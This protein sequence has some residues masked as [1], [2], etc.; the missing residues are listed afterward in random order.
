MTKTNPTCGEEYFYK[1]HNLLLSSC[2]LL[3]NVFMA[4]WKLETDS[5]WESTE[6]NG[7]QVWEGLGSLVTKSNSIKCAPKNVIQ[8]GCLEEWDLPTLSLLL[9]YYGKHRDVYADDD[10]AV[11]S[12]TRIATELNNSSKRTLTRE[13]YNKNLKTFRKC[14]KVFQMKDDHV[15]DLIQ[16]V[17]VTC[18]S[19]AWDIIKNLF[20]K[21]KCHMYSR[22]F[23]DAIMCYTQAIGVPGL[24]PYHQSLAY[25]KRSECY[26]NL[27]EH[28]KARRDPEFEILFDNAIA[29]A[30][31][32]LQFN[33][34]SWKAHQILGQCFKTRESYCQALF[35]F[36]QAL[37]CSP[38]QHQV[39][40]VLEFCRAHVGN[41]LSKAMEN[42]ALH[43]VIKM[44]KVQFFKEKAELEGS[45]IKGQEHVF[46]GHQYTAGWSVEH[47]DSEAFRHYKK[48]AQVQNPEGI[49]HVAL[50]YQ[51]G[52]GVEKELGS[53]HHLFLQAALMSPTTRGF[54]TKNKKNVGVAGAQHALGLMYDNGIHVEQDFAKAAEW[55]EKG[56]EN[57]VGESA[58]NLGNL[59]KDGKKGVEW[60]EKKAAKY[61]KQALNLGDRNAAASLMYY[62][63]KHM[64]VEEA[65]VMLQKGRLLGNSSLLA[66]TDV[67]FMLLPNLCCPYDRNAEE[68]K[69]LA[70]EKQ[71]DL[72]ME[73]RNLTFLER[74]QNYENFKE[75]MEVWSNKV[76]GG[77]WCSNSAPKTTS[78]IPRKRAKAVI[79]NDTGSNPNP[80]MSKVDPKMKVDSNSEVQLKI[81]EAIRNLHYLT[82]L[83]QKKN[84][85]N[86]AEQKEIVNIMYK[87]VNDD[88]GALELTQD[89]YKKM[90]TV[91]TQL[92]KSKF[93]KKSMV[94]EEDMKIRYCFIHLSLHDTESSV[95][96]QNSMKLAKKGV[97]M[98]PENPYY[99]CLVSFGYN[100]L[101]DHEGGLR[102]VEKALKQ[103]PNQL[104]LLNTKVVHLD[105]VLG[106]SEEE[107][108]R[109]IEAYN[110]YIQAL[111]NDHWKVPKIYYKMT[112][113]YKSVAS[114]ENREEATLRARGRMSHYFVRG[115][116]AENRVHSYFQSRLTCKY[117]PILLKFLSKGI[118]DAILKV[119][120][121]SNNQQ[122]TENG[123]VPCKTGVKAAAD[124][125]NEGW[126]RIESEILFK[127]GKPDSDENEVS[128]ETGAEFK[129]PYKLQKRQ[130]HNQPEQDEADVHESHENI[131]ATAQNH[132][133]LQEETEVEQPEFFKSPLEN[134][135]VTPPE[136][137]SVTESTTSL[138]SLSSTLKNKLALS[139]ASS[140]EASENIEPVVSSQVSETPT[141]GGSRTIT[142][143][144]AI[145]QPATTPRSSS[146]NELGSSHE[147]PT[148]DNNYNDFKSP[149]SPPTS[150]VA[151]L[152]ER[153]LKQSA[154]TDE[155]AS[156]AETE[157]L[158]ESPNVE[159]VNE[160]PI[161]LAAG[162]APPVYEM[163]ALTQSTVNNELELSHDPPSTDVLAFL[164]SNDPA[165]NDT[166]KSSEKSVVTEPVP[167]LNV[168]PVNELEIAASN[169]V[170]VNEFHNVPPVYKTSTSLPP[171]APLAK[172]ILAMAEIA[173]TLESITKTEFRSSH[174]ND[175]DPETSTPPSEAAAVIME[176]TLST[177]INETGSRT[178][179]KVAYKSHNVPI[180]N[181][182]QSL[183]SAPSVIEILANNASEESSE[184]EV[185]NEFNSSHDAPSTNQLALASDFDNA[186]AIYNIDKEPGS[187]PPLET[188]AVSE[189]VP[190]SHESPATIENA[191]L[192][193][194]DVFNESHNVPTANEIP[195]MISA[196]SDDEAI[197]ITESAAENELTISNDALS[198]KE[199]ASPSSD[200]DQAT[201]TS[202][203]GKSSD[204][205]II[206][207]IY[208]TSTPTP[209]TVPSLNETLPTP[210]SALTLKFTDPPSAPS[211]LSPKGQCVTTPKTEA[212]DKASSPHKSPIAT[213]IRSTSAASVNLETEMIREPASPPRPKTLLLN[214]AAAAK[215]KPAFMGTEHEVQKCQPSD[216]APKPTFNETIPISRSTIFRN[217]YDPLCFIRVT[218][219]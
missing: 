168:Q 202:E 213:T 79:A 207:E 91:V 18:S 164:S 137:S 5:D 114:S 99:H 8:K 119:G 54:L 214:G 60:S 149:P 130:V 24:I 51:D 147:T 184:T 189:P 209:P 129:A 138:K 23:D 180:V 195:T 26:L 155:T 88:Y 2:H 113:C 104:Q 80:T 109:R 22:K 12:L 156:L 89:I 73:A 136:A 49:Y 142:E 103:F 143:M 92:Y 169:I 117:K 84:S 85:F 161:L 203:T 159:A 16:S 66:L 148:E 153:I 206:S 96:L 198:T 160:N 31:R 175:N 39:K 75:R 67:D 212:G 14:V 133:A 50:C 190:S 56:A 179:A 63:I 219:C 76:C 93:E 172:E 64:E 98:Y 134:E 106:Q 53:A 21:A 71:H 205:Q 86:K 192:I 154:T 42:N 128:V 210:Q 57:G 95:G 13:E 145:N 27:A 9:Q 208:R 131:T 37:Q 11:K 108:E 201:A 191:S 100:Q 47:N 52:R 162:A 123:I 157:V 204:T 74:L 101:N 58:N 34:S 32:S 200:E 121:P 90:K 194:V 65:R 124:C 125:V 78:K 187:P 33:S 10:E 183:F 165:T 3:Q 116:E 196:F 126:D 69:V 135:F 38:G 182:M 177:P 28:L 44:S 83:F 146:N 152:I 61:W 30:N 132:S 178:E 105:E 55:Y 15:K 144:E 167:S 188:V 87:S 185:N 70:F 173:K 120:N 35:H 122:V 181:E 139:S 140:Q 45:K 82:Q 107:I 170:S 171:I 1:L 197:V 20:E 97:E 150:E 94:G 176:P 81:N 218:T 110:E 59:Y 19:A 46:L 216:K 72:E 141:V 7:K 127:Y 199:S 41:E 6:E 158:E 166:T 111:P 163:L 112:N 40:K 193:K 4:R 215:K 17:G 102:Y 174:D 25:D 62:Y 36:E 217:L 115:C 29:D 77:E 151:A 118:C 186:A 48:A 211:P 68:P 43:K